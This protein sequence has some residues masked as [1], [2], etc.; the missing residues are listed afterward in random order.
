MKT[1]ELGTINDAT[2]YAVL[3]AKGMIALNKEDLEFVTPQYE[4]KCDSGCY[5]VANFEQ[6]ICDKA[7]SELI[8]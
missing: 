3:T 2:V 7:F 4:I 1:I 5:P 6:Y 8:L